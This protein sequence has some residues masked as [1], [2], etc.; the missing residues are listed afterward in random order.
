MPGSLILL[1]STIASRLLLLRRILFLALLILWHLVGAR[2]GIMPGVAALVAVSVNRRCCASSGGCLTLCWGCRAGLLILRP[3][4]L[5]HWLPLATLLVALL[6]LAT[7]LVAL[8]VVLR[9][10]L[11]LVARTSVADV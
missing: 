2:I 7:L 5:S 8:L 10:L 4:S 1:T 11:L 3:L 6:S 9:L